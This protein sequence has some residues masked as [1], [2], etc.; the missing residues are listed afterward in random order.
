[1]R[2]SSA[3]PLALAAICARRSAR[4][5]AGSRDGYSAVLSS[6]IV[7]ASR[8][9]VLATR[10]QLSISTPSSSTRVLLA[11]IDPATLRRSRRGA[12]GWPRR[13]RC[14]PWCREDGSDH[15]DVGEVGAAVVRVVEDVDVAA[16]D[17]R[18]ALDH[19]LDRLAHGAQVHR[20]VRRVGDQAAVGVEDRAGK[21]EPLLDV[22][23]VRGGLQ[24]HPHLF[25]DRHE[26]VVEDLEHAPGRR[27]CPPGPLAGRAVTRDSSRSPRSLTTARQPG[28]DHGG[29]EFLGDD[30]RAVDGVPGPQPGPREQVHL[31]PSAVGEHRH[32]GG[33]DRP[34]LF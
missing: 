21:V 17:A 8:S 14:R 9:R 27:S 11:G 6:S 30:G 7:S 26:Q 13:T 5:V 28:L 3:M 16:A 31:L 33:A 1:M 10:S 19:H 18:V 4:F 32:P 24:A 22:D 34:L 15:G 23:R 25:G 2:C 20:H 12:R 29:G